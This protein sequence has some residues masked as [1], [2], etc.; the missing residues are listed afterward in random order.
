M[1]SPT[2][3]RT[4]ADAA[5]EIEKIAAATAPSSTGTWTPFQI[6]AHCTQSLH[7]TIDGF[8]TMKPALVRATVGWLVKT[9]FILRGRMSHGLVT[10]IA[11]APTIPADGD[12]RAAATD[13]LAA[14]AA[15]RSFDRP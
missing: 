11:G 15:L 6:V 3:L 14:I 10:P 4:L 5:R 2:S 9:V 8:P 13:A 7:Y 12:V 1:S